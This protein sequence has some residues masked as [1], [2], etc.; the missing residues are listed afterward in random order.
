MPVLEE[1]YLAESE[2]Y[3]ETFQKNFLLCWLFITSFRLYIM[4]VTVTKKKKAECCLI[5]GKLRTVPRLFVDCIFE[6]LTLASR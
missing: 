3:I 2:S 5:G 1:I 4:Y 6:A